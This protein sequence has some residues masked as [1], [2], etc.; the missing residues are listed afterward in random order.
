MVHCAERISNDNDDDEYKDD[1]YLRKLTL[2]NID[3]YRQVQR[4]VVIEAWEISSIMTTIGKIKAIRAWE[5][6]TKM[7]KK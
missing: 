6:M 7:T 2:G 4:K 1:V 5:K 3:Q